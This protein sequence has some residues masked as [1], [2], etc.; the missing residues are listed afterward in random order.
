M[1]YYRTETTPLKT[2]I[3]INYLES[4]AISKMDANSTLSVTDCFK[5]ITNGEFIYLVPV[6]TVY[7]ENTNRREKKQIRSNVKSN[8]VHQKLQITQTTSSDQY[9]LQWR[10]QIVETR[11]GKFSNRFNNRALGD[12]FI[13]L[14]SNIWFSG[15]FLNLY[16]E[17]ESFRWFGSD[18]FTSTSPHFFS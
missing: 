8:E 13:W 6:I 10:S 9:N 2:E 1:S 16:A 12:S 4:F 17:N 7:H 5:A 15:N 14:G 18:S 3:A 11:F